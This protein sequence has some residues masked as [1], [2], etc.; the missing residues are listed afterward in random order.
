MIGRS[1]I[2]RSKIGSW[3]IVVCHNFGLGGDKCDV[4][5][6]KYDMNRR[7]IEPECAL[8]LNN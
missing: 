7:G 5:V 2:D 1:T 6:C 3:M 8:S 4:V